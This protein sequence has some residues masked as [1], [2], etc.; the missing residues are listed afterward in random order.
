LALTGFCIFSLPMENTILR[1]AHVSWH[2]T[3][4]T[5]QVL[6]PWRQRQT[7]SPVCW[8]ESITFWF[9]AIHQWRFY[10]FCGTALF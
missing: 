10:Y 3:H 4:L 1:S 5:L 7:V 6:R 9:V 8:H 2:Y